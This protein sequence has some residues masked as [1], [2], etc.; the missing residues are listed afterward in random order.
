MREL[1]ELNDAYERR[2]GFRFVVFVNG[3]TKADLVPVLRARLG[4]TRTE[5][6]STGFSEFQAIARDR[7]EHPR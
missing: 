4:R 6:L 1:A 5:E 2:F 7:S 3:R